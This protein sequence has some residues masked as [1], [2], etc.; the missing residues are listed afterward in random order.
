MEG[1]SSAEQ[2]LVKT[3]VKR[4]RDFFQSMADTIKVYLAEEGEE[5][6]ESTVVKKSS[7]KKSPRKAKKSKSKKSLKKTKPPKRIQR[8]PDA[9]KK[10]LPAF[11]LYSNN[12]RKEMKE[13]GVSKFCCSS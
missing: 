8:D 4:A 5:V 3:V 6:K 10:P 13:E 11:L 2:K 9:P 1:R 12:R 7:T